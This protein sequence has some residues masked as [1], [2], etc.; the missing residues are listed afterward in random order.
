MFIK[1]C[2]KFF[3]FTIVYPIYQCFKSSTFFIITTHK[4]PTIWHI[5]F[6]WIS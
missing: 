3:I 5:I 4:S 1:V 6:I 2:Y